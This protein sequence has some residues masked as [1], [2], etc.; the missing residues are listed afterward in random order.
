LVGL[1]DR[2]SAGDVAAFV[3][4]PHTRYPDGRMPRFPVSPGQ[5]RDIAA[6]LLFWSPPSTDPPPAEGP[7][8][9][10]EV[11]SVARRLGVSA[12]DRASIAAALLTE[13]G[14]TSCHV[15]LGPTLPRQIPIR[16]GNVAGCLSD[17]G[18]PRFGLD[19]PISEAIRAYI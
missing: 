13:K 5:A 14:C 12:R 11:R 16:P 8:S 3:G 19:R 1:R 17:Q 2:M 9:P 15:G 18:L 10:D 4:N 6:Y 7:P